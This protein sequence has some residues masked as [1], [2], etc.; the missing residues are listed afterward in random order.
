MR[1]LKKVLALMLALA[2]ALSVMAGAF[3]VPELSEEAKAECETLTAAQKDAFFVISE[4]GIAKGYTDGSFRPESNLTRAE[5]ATMVYRAKTGDVN[6]TNTLFSSAS[7]AMFKDS[8]DA[9]AVPYIAYAYSAGIVVGYPDGTFKPNQAV[10][11]LEAAKMLLTALGYDAEIEGLVGPTFFTNTIKLGTAVGLFKGVAGDLYAPISRADAFVMFCNA[12]YANTVTYIGG[13]ATPKTKTLNSNDTITLGEEGFDLLD[14][15]AVLVATSDAALGAYWRDVIVDGTAKSLVYEQYEKAPAGYARFVYRDYVATGAANYGAY[16]QDRLITVALG[17]Q[18]AEFIELGEAYRILT[19]AVN[20]VYNENEYRILYSYPVAKA[21]SSSYKVT[22]GSVD[23]LKA[24]VIDAMEKRAAA[25]VEAD[26]KKDF[27]IWVNGV[28]T[29]FEDAKAYAGKKS[30]A[31]YK[32]VDNDNDGVVDS[33]FIY[34]YTIGTVKAIADETI[35]IV[36]SGLGTIKKADFAVLPTL[37]A[38]DYVA[39]YKAAGKYYAKKLDVAEAN[40]TGYDGTN[41]TINGSKYVFGAYTSDS[42]KSLVGAGAGA[43]TETKYKYVFDGKYIVN[44]ELTENTRYAKYALLSHNVEALLAIFNAKYLNY[45]PV[46]LYTEDNEYVT[47][48]VKGINGVQNYNSGMNFAKFIAENLNIEYSVLAQMIENI[49]I[50]LEAAVRDAIIDTPETDE[51]LDEIIDEYGLDSILKLLK[52]I[53]TPS[54]VSYQLD[55]DYV[56][57]DIIGPIN[58]NYSGLKQLGETFDGSKISDDYDFIFNRATQTWEGKTKN[59]WISMKDTHGVVFVTYD[60][61]I[62]SA[63]TDVLDTVVPGGV[64]DAVEQLIKDILNGDAPFLAPEPERADYQTQ[65]EYEDAVE[66]YELAIDTYFA[67]LF[68]GEVNVRNIVSILA[69]LVSY[70]KTYRAYYNGEFQPS[71]YNDFEAKIHDGVN[72]FIVYTTQNGV[73]F[74]KAAVISFDHAVYPLPGLPTT[75]SFDN[76]V[77]IKSIAVDSSDG[78]VYTY[79]TYAPWNEADLTFKSVK[80][81]APQAQP[82]LNTV[83]NLKTNADGAVTGHYAVDML[84]SG[85][86]EDTE[87]VLGTNG[88]E[89]YG[90]LVTGFNMDV[91]GNINMTLTNIGKYDALAPVFVNGDVLVQRRAPLQE[92]FQFPPTQIVDVLASDTYTINVKADADV[93]FFEADENGKLTAKNWMSYINYDY[94]NAPVDDKFVAFVDMNPTTQTA[95]RLIIVAGAYA[96]KL[97]INKFTVVADCT[98]NTLTKK[99]E[100]AFGNTLYTIAD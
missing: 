7:V 54:L 45:A 18:V 41:F 2:M 59:S 53:T 73:N 78:W 88:F 49:D 28:A 48:Y 14:V 46:T 84:N 15:E 79:T 9:W 94:N 40:V 34:D 24:E 66:A 83:W 67:D 50:I 35:T 6:D 69:N 99:A 57:L 47:A 65:K 87:Y 81:A 82:K 80:F 8:I 5:F 26:D 17:D 63:I 38:G 25:L 98:Y 11:G 60:G 29:S 32:S 89:M 68:A 64:R 23:G 75:R 93:W 31:P 30:T 36:G 72:D 37:A 92:G 56:Y 39:I 19:T 90:Y 52:F 100:Y 70:E 74:F 86:L 77:I 58:Y 16:Y 71:Y 12:L 4:L 33:L 42:S 1:N 3:T 96:D 97:S 43:L 76:L 27:T 21:N 91:F 51:A 61:G 13:V 22:N 55:G 44:V 10:T 62:I 95:N 85:L 20:E